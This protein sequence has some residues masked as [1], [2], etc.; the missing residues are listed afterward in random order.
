[1]KQ[2]YLFITVSILL[3]C[4][5]KIVAQILLQPT[6]Q[7]AKKEIRCYTVEVINEFR[8]KHPNAETDAQFELSL[9]KKMQERKTLRTML[10]N[11][12][13]PVIFH[14][15]HNGELPGTSSNLSAASISQQILQ[16]N[17]DFA[18]LSRDCLLATPTLVNQRF[19]FR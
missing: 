15:I 5:Q 19:D 12:T 1:M 7:T 3:A 11:Y 18:N 14:I 9:S 2:F 17:K 16:L 10:A 13:I 4:S 8:K 6:A